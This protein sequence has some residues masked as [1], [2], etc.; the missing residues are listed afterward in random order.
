MTCHSNS[1]TYLAL[2]LGR[3]AF[4]L[5]AVSINGRFEAER[6]PGLA[7]RPS[8]G[9][10]AFM[11]P[12]HP[13][14]STRPHGLVQAIFWHTCPDL[15][16]GPWYIRP[17]LHL[18]GQWLAGFASRLVP[19]LP[20]PFI[21]TLIGLQA[22]DLVSSPVWWEAAT[23]IILTWLIQWTPGVHIIKP[24]TWSQKTPHPKQYLLGKTECFAWRPERGIPWG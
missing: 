23:N 21:P 12:M 11:T 10:A 6:P 8:G 14:Y 7:G 18:V 19:D 17:T 16:L 15:D 3:L 4:V 2:W 5:D 1:H 13:L 20:P 22:F 9:R 24:I